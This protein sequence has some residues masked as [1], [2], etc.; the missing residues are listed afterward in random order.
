MMP[1]MTPKI[2]SADAKISMMRILTKREPFCA[3]ARA[4][5]L[6]TMPTQTLEDDSKKKPRIENQEARNSRERKS[7]E[8]RRKE[9]ERSEEEKQSGKEGEEREEEE[10]RESEGEKKK[11]ERQEERTRTTSCQGPL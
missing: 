11:R 2:P 8:R 10:R 5:E 7:G 3:S 1:T 4:Q 9:E 6:P